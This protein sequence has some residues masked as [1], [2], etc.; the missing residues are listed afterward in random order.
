MDIFRL[1]EAMTYDDFLLGP[2][3]PPLYG[4]HETSSLHLAVTILN[5]Q[6]TD[7]AKKQTGGQS[8]ISESTQG[9]SGSYTLENIPFPAPACSFRRSFGRTAVSL[10]PSNLIGKPQACHSVLAAHI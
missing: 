4:A 10:S 8:S 9:L 7:F 2:Y 5:K 6:A 1:V 3:R